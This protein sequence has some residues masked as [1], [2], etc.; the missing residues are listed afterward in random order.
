MNSKFY[1]DM[2]GRS[3]CMKE[4]Y[5]EA[6]A[7]DKEYN[8]SVTF[9]DIQKMKKLDSLVKETLRHADETR[10]IYSIYSKYSVNE[11]SILT[12]LI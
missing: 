7:I 2:A 10:T 9:T 3:E 4:L 11:K 1:L 6:L 12:L 5:E 8:G